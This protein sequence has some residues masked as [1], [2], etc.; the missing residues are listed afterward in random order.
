MVALTAER[1]TVQRSGAVFSRGVAANAQIY[2]GA[3]VA[4]NAAGFLVPGSASTT[5][6]ADGKATETVRGT[7]VNGEAS[8]QVERGVFRFANSAAADQITRADIGND[9]WIVDD[10]QVARTNGGGTRSVAGRIEDVDAQGVW[11]RFIGGQ[12]GG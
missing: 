8:C 5:L 11:V 1:D 6:K 4:L 3:L 10:D 7:A 2:A 9:C 12:V